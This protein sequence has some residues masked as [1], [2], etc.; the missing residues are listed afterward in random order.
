MTT[1]PRGVRLPAALLCALALL[2]S[3]QPLLARSIEARVVS[4][5]DGDTVQVR[6]RGSEQEAVRLLYIDAPEHDQPGGREARR[7]LQELVRVERVRIETRGRDRYG[8]T[9]GHLRR[10]PDGLDV[11]LELVRRGH[12][13][14]NA[15]GAMRPRYEAA[16][17]EARA[18]RRGLWRAPNPVSPYQWRHRA[19][20]R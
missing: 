2:V 9:L 4:V 11:N 14:A 19:R 16:E 8:R 7:A 17:R 1:C 5:A 3:A 18:A 6:S 12:A 15:R 13:W 10:L 20:N